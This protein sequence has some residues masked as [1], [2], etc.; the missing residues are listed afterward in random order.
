MNSLPDLLCLGIETSCDDTSISL[1]RPPKI[2]SNIVSSQQHFRKFGG[3]VPELAARDHVKNVIPI[4]Q[5]ALDE[6]EVKLK[7][8]SMIAVTHTPGLIGSLLVGLHF[9]KG[10]AFALGIPLVGVNHIEAHFLA[11]FLEHPKM[12]FPYMALIV[13][14]GH[15]LLVKV[16]SFKSY[17][18]L[19]KTKDDAAG[20]CFDK[21]A[22]LLDMSNKDHPDM[23]GPLID[24]HA[25]EGNPAAFDF[26][27]PLLNS[28]DYDFSFSGLKTSMLNFCR[29]RSAEFMTEN[30]NDICASF[31]E[32][33]VDVLVRKT[34]KAC[35]DHAVTNVFLSGGVAANS[36]LRDRLRTEGAAANLAVFLP[37]REYC[38]D[39]AAMIAFTGLVNLHV[40]LASDLTLTAQAALGDLGEKK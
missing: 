14:G 34:I 38:T 3:I 27:R 25:A 2:L 33:A 6:A 20:E 18:I 35:R 21:V 30:M 37:A 12:D 40:G 19:G 36:R 10:L 17:T 32:A 8:V 31:Q 9:A 4:L 5:R 22:R 23:G 24:R 15:T 13:S 39:N 16:N 28:P 1:F 29:K 26:P 11:C 7:D